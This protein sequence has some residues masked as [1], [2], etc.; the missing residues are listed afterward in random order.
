M[1]PAIVAKRRCGGAEREVAI[2]QSGRDAGIGHDDHIVVDGRRQ[3]RDDI[4]EH[5]AVGRRL[6]LPGGNI[7]GDAVQTVDPA[8]AIGRRLP[9]GLDQLGEERRRVANDPDIRPEMPPDDRAVAIDMDEL[10]MRPGRCGKRVAL[11]REVAEPGAERQDQIGFRE[12]GKLRRA[13]ADAEI[14]GI[15]RISMRKEIVTTEAD[16]DRNRKTLGSVAEELPP[17]P[18]LE[19]AAGDDQRALGRLEQAQ[20]L[21]N[22]VLTGR[23]HRARQGAQLGQSDRL[24]ED[25]LGKRDHH[26]PRNA[27]HRDIHRPRDGLDEAVGVADLGD[28]L[29]D[30]AIHL[31]VVD[32]LEAVTAE[33]AARDLADEKNER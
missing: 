6:R 2:E 30:V 24:V 22:R 32:L 12:G 23:R 15:V 10:L 9:A 28:H 8:L 17:L 33:M 1:T 27:A 11:G 14:A 7:G 16:G 19:L 25:I 3:G 20:R 5:D 21:C 26:R 4:A 18:R 13:V 29:G 31:A